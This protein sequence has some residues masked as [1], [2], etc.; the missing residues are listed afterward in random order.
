[1]IVY[2]EL[3]TFKKQNI[4][5][6]YKM[7]NFGK[8]KKLLLNKKIQIYDFAWTCKHFDKLLIFL[9]CGEDFGLSDN[10]LTSQGIQTLSYRFTRWYAAK[11]VYYTM[12]A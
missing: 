2:E 11:H 1:M 8:K 10:S 7:K 6:A 9:I 5:S 4:N 12:H 3:K